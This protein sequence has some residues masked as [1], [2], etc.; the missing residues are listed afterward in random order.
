LALDAMISSEG[1]LFEYQSD[2]QISANLEM[3]HAAMPAEAIAV[4]SATHD[5][6]PARLALAPAGVGGPAANAGRV[7]R[8]C[9]TQRMAHRCV[10]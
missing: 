4:G 2:V 9:S 5:D 1:G 8:P 7:R 3:L 10:D 6:E